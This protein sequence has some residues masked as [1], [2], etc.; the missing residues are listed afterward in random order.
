MI[1]CS[2]VLWEM[3]CGGC[4]HSVCLCPRGAVVITLSPTPKCISI[5][6]Q[7][8]LRPALPGIRNLFAAPGSP[9]SPEKAMRWNS[10]SSFPALG[11][12]NSNTSL[13]IPFLAGFV[14]LQLRDLCCMVG[15]SSPFSPGPPGPALQSSLP[16]PA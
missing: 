13:K 4:L 6:L 5:S 8:F 3:P 16:A 14:L 10:T 12:W 2:S 15:S 11:V 9:H 1:W 7:L